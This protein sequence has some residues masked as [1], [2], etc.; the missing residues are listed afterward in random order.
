MRRLVLLLSLLACLGVPGAVQASEPRA[1]LPD[2]EDEVMCVQCGT[3]LSVSNSAVADDQ[4]EFIRKRIARGESKEQIKQAMAAELGPGVLAM[5][6]D[7]GF[8]LAAYIV[9]VVLLGLGMVGVA[10]AAHRWR[11]NRRA[12]GTALG[13]HAPGLDPADEQRLATELAAFDR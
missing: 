1:S 8:D 12:R 3:A 4:R 11:R 2:I 13:G 6:Q 9:P 5:P 10:V 7:E